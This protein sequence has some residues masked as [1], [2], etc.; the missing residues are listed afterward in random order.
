MNNNNNYYNLPKKVRFCKKSLISNQRPSSTQEYMHTLN[1]KKKT[2]FIDKYGVSDSWKYSRL[3]K[4]INYKIREK[5][6]LKLLD[7][8]RGKYGQFDCIVPGSGGKDSCF[9]AH[10]LKY[11]YG[12]NPLTVTWP[13]ILYTDY[14]YKN[15]K[16]WL[17][18][19]NFENIL[20]KRNEELMRFLTKK[21]ITNL[22][23]PFQTFILGQKQFAPKIALKLGIP[24]V[25]YGENEAE[26][27]NSIAEN[28]DSIRDKSFYSFKNLKQIYLGGISYVDLVS[29][30]KIN[31]KDLDI[32]LPP[33]LNDI[34][35]KKLE[36]HYLG[37]FLKW[38]PQECYYYAVDNS[39]FR[40]RP[41]RTQGTYSKYNSIDDK[42]DDLHYYT[43]FIKFGIG[44]AT[45]DV[46]QEI[47]N[48]HLDTYEGKKLI[49][50]FDGEFPDRYFAEICDYLGIKQDVF[51]RTC[52]KFRPKHLWKKTK[53]EWKLR[54]NVNKTGTD[55]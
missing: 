40:P 19:G 50:K 34:K 27:G 11:K 3:K 12:M 17:E 13:P 33:A 37:Y 15:Y 6:L 18:K 26:H 9:A 7:K 48:N 2:L 49:E 31:K 52:D 35:N 20:P 55:D 4:N 25:F 39:N 46:S 10:I 21:S 8:H 14:G 45:Y 53:G 24:L 36:V 29:K 51:H 54:H 16:S 30:F 23:H 47:R 32:F 5:K 1:Q 28:F 41:F 22:L 38:I 42:I 43:T 44:R